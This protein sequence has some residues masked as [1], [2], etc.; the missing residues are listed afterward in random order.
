MAAQI[1]ELTFLEHLAGRFKLPVPDH[2]PADATGAE[3]RA[4][5]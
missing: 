1:T 4:A 2:L 5:L 3:I